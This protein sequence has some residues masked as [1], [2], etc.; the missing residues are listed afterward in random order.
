MNG[1]ISN[2][3]VDE[4]GQHSF[5]P[6][7]SDFFVMSAVVID[8]SHGLHQAGE[9]LAQIR[10][11]LGRGPEDVLHWKQI[12]THSQRLRAVQMIGLSSFITVSSVVVCKRRFTLPQ[13]YWPND[14]DTYLN[15]LAMLLKRL[16]WIAG[17]CGTVMRYTLAHIVRF[18]VATLRQHEAALRGTTYEIDWRALDPR[19]GAIDQPANNGH[20]Q[21]ADL[22]AS[23]IAA[24]FE[25]DRYGN[26]ETRY[27]V[28]LAPRFYRRS[29]LT[30]SESGL[31]LYPNPGG[32][33]EVRQAFPWLRELW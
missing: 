1:K 32:T 26:V 17:N 27:P 3:F 14:G 8:S 23:A 4:S 6:R 30:L 18:K 5:S 11:D 29:D 10:R 19:G 33:Q 22:A 21:L 12:K 28:E 25:P 20:L 13:P 7:S 2:A 24:A 16:S 9:L 15:T 31:K